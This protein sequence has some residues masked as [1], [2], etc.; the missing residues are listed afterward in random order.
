MQN[1]KQADIL[2]ETKENLCLDLGKAIYRMERG[3]MN[4]GIFY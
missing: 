4:L 2:L 3:H 1:L